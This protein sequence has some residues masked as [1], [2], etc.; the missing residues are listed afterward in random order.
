MRRPLRP[1]G[2]RPR[3]RGAIAERRRHRDSGSV[4]TTTTT[5]AVVGAIA[6]MR[7]TGEPAGHCAR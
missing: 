5:E 4:L 1:V 7:V 2:Y 6:V 3:A